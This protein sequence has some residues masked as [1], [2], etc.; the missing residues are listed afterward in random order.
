MAGFEFFAGAD[1]FYIGDAVDG[2]DAI[3][4]IDFVLQEFGEVAVVSGAEFLRRTF[5]VLI[6]DGDFAVAFDLHEDGEEAEAGIPDY[7]FFFAAFDDFRIDEGP[8]FFSWKLQEDYALEDAELGGGDAASVA[9][10]GAPVGQGVGEVLDK[11]GDF[12]GGGICDCEGFL[13][14]DGVAELEDGA[15]R[16]GISGFGGRL[17]CPSA[18]LQAQSTIFN[19]KSEI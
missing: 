18:I 16:H 3:E 8:G 19:L 12:G 14:E 4:V 7:D 17:D 5:D 2:E 13:A 6:A 11:G 9:G 10:G 1:G 15:E